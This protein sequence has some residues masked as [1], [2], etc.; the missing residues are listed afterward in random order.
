MTHGHP[1]GETFSPDDLWT[2]LTD[3]RMMELRAVTELGHR[4]MND[5]LER[6]SEY[7]VLRYERT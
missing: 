6:F 7:G 5:L 2:F 1:S 3:R 4:K